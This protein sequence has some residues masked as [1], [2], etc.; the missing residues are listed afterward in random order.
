MKIS[1]IDKNLKVETNIQKDDIVWFSPRTAP[2]RIHG[3]V[4]AETD[5]PYHRLPESTAAA[6]GSAVHDLMWCTAGGRVRFATNSPYIAIKAVMWNATETMPHITKT[7]QSGFD[8]YTY[9]DGGHRYIA[10]FIPPPGLTSGYESCTFVN[11]EMKTYTINM[12]LYD[13]VKELYIGLAEGSDLEEPRP[14]TNIVPVVYYGSSITQGGCASRPGN[15]YQSMIERQLDTDYVNLGFSGSA[16]GETVIAK[17]LA[18]LTASVFVCDYD[19]NASLEGLKETHLPLY[20]IYRA[21]NPDT[22]VIFVSKPDFRTG[23]DAERRAVIYNTYKTARAEGD[24]NVYFIDGEQ[25]FTGELRDSCTVDGCHPN[26]L[27][28]F[29]MSQVIGKEIRKVL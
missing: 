2:F 7:G 5:M 27:G 13:C 9:A 8:L 26:D 22:P 21:K 16:R 28:F 15:A 19:H 3:L 24:E 12:P 18:S 14:Y 10:T 11:P 23:E 29:R 25:L 1:K 20:R 4:E 6:T 17:Y